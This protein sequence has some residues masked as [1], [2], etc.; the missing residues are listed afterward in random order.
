MEA[1]VVY[2]LYIALR[3]VSPKIWRRVE[4]TVGKLVGRPATRDP[5]YRSDGPTNISTDS[6]S[7][8]IIWANL[9]RLACC[10]SGIQRQ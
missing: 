2:R 4:L 3:D 9:D 7:A 10:S 5:R 8:I 1:M 6:A